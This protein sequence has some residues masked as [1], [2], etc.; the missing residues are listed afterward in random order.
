[1]ENGIVKEKEEKIFRHE[2][3]L[4]RTGKKAGNKGAAV[5]MGQ[6]SGAIRKVNGEGIGR[7]AKKNIKRKTEGLLK[8][9]FSVDAERVGGIKRSSILSEKSVTGTMGGSGFNSENKWGIRDILP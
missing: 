7:W 2:G 4:G 3:R 5:P 8:L 9:V 6:R 1:M